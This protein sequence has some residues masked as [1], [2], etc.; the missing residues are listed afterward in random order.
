MPRL[1]RHPSHIIPSYSPGGA[2][3]PSA[4]VSVLV[5][6]IAGPTSPRL[7]RHPSLRF[8]VK[9]R[10]QPTISGHVTSQPTTSGPAGRG[11]DHFGSSDLSANHFRS[12][13][14]EADHFRSRDLSAGHFRCGGGRDSAGRVHATDHVAAGGREREDCGRARRDGNGRVGLTNGL[15]WIGSGWLRA[16]GLR[17]S[18]T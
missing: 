16:R 18:A 10:P 13:G 1:D 8:S 15:G 3:V 11:A 6:S 4:R 9:Q 17:P 2:N 5:H 14:C 12:G 7:D